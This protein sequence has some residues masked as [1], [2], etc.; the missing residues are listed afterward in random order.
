[1]VVKLTFTSRMFQNKV[2]RSKY[3]SEKQEEQEDGENYS[4]IINICTII[5]LLFNFNLIKESKMNVACNT[6]LRKEKC[7]QSRVSKPQGSCI[8]VKA[9]N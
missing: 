7:T 2:L 4:S 1:V 3:G 8:S 9:R 6:H 5:Y